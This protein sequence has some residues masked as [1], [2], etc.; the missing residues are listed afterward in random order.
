MIVVL[1]NGES[2]KNFPTQKSVI[3]CNAIFRDQ[4][5]DRL[6]CV[7]PN[8]LEESLGSKNTKSTAIYTRKEWMKVFRD[9]RLNSICEIPYQPTDK[10]DYDRHW[11][12]GTHAV[13]LAGSLDNE[14]SLIGFDLYPV[15][16]KINNIYKNTLGYCSKDSP[17]VNPVFW[18]HQISQ[19]F[20]YYIDKYFIIYNFKGW[21]PPSEWKLPNVTIKPLDSFPKK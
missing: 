11:G 3:G 18:I 7:D 14:I 21:N 17:P 1:G 19:T 20:R 10:M 15:D 9:P 5:I 2:R 4:E 16:G 6:V 13:L 12:S 8:L